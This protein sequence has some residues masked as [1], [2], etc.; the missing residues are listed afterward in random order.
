MFEVLKAFK[1]TVGFSGGWHEEG[2]LNTYLLEGPFKKTQT[3][4]STTL[5]LKVKKKDKN[6]FSV[7]L[8][9]KELKIDIF[10]EHLKVKLNK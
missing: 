10:T 1:L 8:I 2:G 7:W 6:K 4:N 3:S 5:A 9:S